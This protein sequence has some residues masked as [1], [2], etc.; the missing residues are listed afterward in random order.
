M[1]P[2]HFFFSFFIFF[3]CQKQPKGNFDE[4]KSY[5]LKKPEK[6]WEMPF[7]L[8]E[9]SG[10][11][12][13]ENQKIIAQNDEQGKLF[14]F[15]LKN[16]KIEKAIHFS[17]KSDYEDI[18]IKDETAYVLRSDGTI[19]EIIN[20]KTKPKTIKHNTF[21]SKND[22]TEGMFFDATKNRLLIACKGN[23]SVLESKKSRLIYE[24]SLKNNTL[25]PKPFLA[26]SEKEIKKKYNNTDYFAPSGIAIHPV[27]KNI[28]ILSSVGKMMAEY[29]LQGKLLN[30]FNLN[31]PHF[32]Q[33]E[34]IRI[35]KNSDLYISNEA[36]GKKANILKFK[37]QL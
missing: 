26:I 1:K 15:D 3:S 37:Y 2:I 17:K 10:I 19:F 9:I 29:S 32:R 6:I 22:D 5:N 4:C 16:S 24:F 8:N 18:A 14:L 23:S 7:E 28:Y 31:Y 13:L 30:V 25:N 27:T 35:D 20:Y 12:L 11:E 33:P 34:G 21:L 36:R